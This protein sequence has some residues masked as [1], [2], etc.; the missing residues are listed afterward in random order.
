VL[1][2]IML[3]LVVI[4]FAVATAYAALCAD[5]LAPPSGKGPLP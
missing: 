4:S 5:L 2:L 3:A 1:D